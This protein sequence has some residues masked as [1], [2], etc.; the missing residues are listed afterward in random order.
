MTIY[1][2][3]IQRSDIN[4]INRWRNDKSLVDYL[5]APFRFINKE[6]DDKWFDSY[7]SNRSNNIRLAICETDSNN[8]LGVVYLLQ[9]DWLNSS[10]EYA[11]Q[12]GEMSSQGRGVG[13]QA[14]IKI[15]EHAF[16]DLN[17]N[18]VHLTVLASNEKAIGLYNKIGFVEEGKLRKAVFKNGRYV[19]LIQMAILSDE[20]KI[21]HANNVTTCP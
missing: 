18:R 5:G 16:S 2:R 6:V 4:E 7:L 15:L 3:E 10:C 12:I 13:C 20:Y 21:V 19:D 14:T 1:L 17:L 8:L 9:I 11:I